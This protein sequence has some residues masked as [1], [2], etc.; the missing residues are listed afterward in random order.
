MAFPLRT[1]LV[2]GET[3]MAITGRIYQCP[4]SIY[5]AISV[6]LTKQSDWQI[7]WITMLSSPSDVT[8][9]KGFYPHPNSRR[10]PWRGGHALHKSE[11]EQEW[12]CQLVCLWEAAQHLAL[13]KMQKCFCG[14]AKHG[15]MLTLDLC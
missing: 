3:D 7:D 1:A 8:Y 10:N 4:L 6:S 5:K 13:G 12:H 15:E 9:S 11:R 14:T 2:K